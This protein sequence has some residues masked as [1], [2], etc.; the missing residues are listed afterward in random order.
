MALG[1]MA[2]TSAFGSV[3]RKAKRSLVV[4][5]SF[6][7]RADVQ[8][9]QRPAKHASGRVSSNAN[10]TGGRVP[11]G[12]TSCSE[13][14]VNGTTQRL[15][16]PSQRRQCADLTLRTSVTPGSDFRPF[17]AKWHMPTGNFVRFGRDEWERRRN[18]RPMPRQ[19][20]RVA[21]F[22]AR[23]LSERC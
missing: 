9:V 8:R 18:S 3:V 21:I 16:M 11:S 4:S 6:T 20:S 13:K 12:S 10:Q 19:V 7:S 17:K 14:L 22:S 23:G 5:P 1:W 15:S 2:P